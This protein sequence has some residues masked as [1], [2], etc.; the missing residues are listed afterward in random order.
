MPFLTSEEKKMFSFFMDNEDATE[1][2][3][4]KPLSEKRTRTKSIVSE[5][6]KKIAKSEEEDDNYEQK[7]QRFKRIKKSHHKI[8]L[9]K[10]LEHDLLTG[11]FCKNEEKPVKQIKTCQ[12]SEP[13]PRSESETVL[14]A[15]LKLVYQKDSVENIKSIEEEVLQEEL[16]ETQKLLMSQTKFKKASDTLVSSWREDF[17]KKFDVYS[18]D[19]QDNIYSKL[20][21]PWIIIKDEYANIF[22]FTSKHLITVFSLVCFLQTFFKS[23]PHEL[24][25]EEVLDPKIAIRNITGVERLPENYRLMMRFTD[26]NDINAFK[27]FSIMEEGEYMPFVDDFKSILRDNYHP[28][29]SLIK[30]ITSSVILY[31]NDKPVSTEAIDSMLQIENLVLRKN[32]E[33]T[34]PIQSNYGADRYYIEVKK[35]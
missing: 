17:E 19:L 31:K 29:M 18:I 15:D 27:Q 7:E 23:K 10:I 28:I 35:K 6:I 3:S 21:Y 2:I 4:E 11:I 33:F 12:K 32:I 20:K 14:H 25:Y 24:Y 16:I 13:V 8:S 26:E 22:G 30:Q 1:W 9:K 5:T 34:K